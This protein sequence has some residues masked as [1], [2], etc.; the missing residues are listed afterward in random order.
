VSCAEVGGL[1]MSLFSRLLSSIGLLI[2]DLVSDF[3]LYRLQP[4]DALVSGRIV[5]S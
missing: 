5:D 1:Y 4:I 3:L 2:E